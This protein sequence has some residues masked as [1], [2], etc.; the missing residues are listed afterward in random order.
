MEEKKRRRH[1]RKGVNPDDPGMFAAAAFLR[2]EVCRRMNKPWARALEALP[3]EL[4]R[5]MYHLSAA[6]LMFG[7][8]YGGPDGWEAGKPD[9]KLTHKMSSLLE[10]KFHLLAALRYLEIDGEMYVADDADEAKAV[11]ECGGDNVAEARALLIDAL[12]GLCGC[13]GNP[14]AP[15][16]AV[17]ANIYSASYRLRCEAERTAEKLATARRAVS[18]K[19]GRR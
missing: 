14:K 9:C 5:P 2:H 1:R 7:S 18:P 3:P 4:L 11:Q 8:L 13:I 10:A 19:E 16:G 6:S 15:K 12:A 17:K